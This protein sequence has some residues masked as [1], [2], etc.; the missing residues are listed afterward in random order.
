MEKHIVLLS[1]GQSAESAVS[2][3]SGLAVRESLERMGHKVTVIDPVGDFLEDIKRIQPDVVFNALHG[4]YG[5]DGAIPGALEVMAIPYTHSGIL[6]SSVCMNKAFTKELLSRYGIVSPAGFAMP[7]SEFL[8]QEA[9]G[10]FPLSKPYVVKPVSQGSTVGVYLIKAGESFAQ[11]NEENPWSYG[12]MALIE[13]YIEGQ[14]L[15]G[16]VIGGKCLGVIEL[17]PA[18]GFYDYESKYMEGKTEH[19]YPAQIPDSFYKLAQEWSELAHSKLHCR[20]ISRSDFRYDS[21]RQKL[22]FL[23]INTHPGFT[24][25]SLVPEVAGY[26]GMTFDDVVALL[27]SEARLDLTPYL[28]AQAKAKSSIVAA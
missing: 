14:E 27:L 21:E 24:K 8:E 25:L 12:E 3:Q 4:T 7:L 19:I 13:E 5:E 15:S 1:G 9:A 28:D 6:S 20:S 22:F 17:R 23:E 18:S 26:N 11:Q 10:V 16:V 2:I